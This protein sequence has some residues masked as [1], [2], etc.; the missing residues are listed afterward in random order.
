MEYKIFL[1]LDRG[2]HWITE[3]EVSWWHLDVLPTAEDRLERDVDLRTGEERFW[4]IEALGVSSL[5][6]KDPDP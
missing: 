5:L 2:I 1:C 4:H 6:L 3:T